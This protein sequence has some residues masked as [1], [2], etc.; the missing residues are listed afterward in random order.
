[1]GRGGLRPGLRVW[2]GEGATRGHPPPTRFVAP[3]GPSS[4]TTAAHACLLSE[5][6]FFTGQSWAE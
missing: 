4:P 3:W 5:E 6:P 1:M 2:V